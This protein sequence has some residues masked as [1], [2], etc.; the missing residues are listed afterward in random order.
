MGIQS[1]SSIA[2]L[3][4]FGELHGDVCS[5]GRG[6]TSEEYVILLSSNTKKKNMYEE[7][8]EQLPE[9]V[10]NATQNSALG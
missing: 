8:V 2:F 3:R 7:Y 10:D 4:R 6:S 5:T 9:R 1:K